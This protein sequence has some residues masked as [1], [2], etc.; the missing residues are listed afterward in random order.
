M[1]SQ[2]NTLPGQICQHTQKRRVRLWAGGEHVEPAMGRQIGGILLPR[3]DGKGP[4]PGSWDK[5][6]R[7]RQRRTVRLEG[8]QSH[9]H[10]R[11]GRQCL[12]GGWAVC[13]VLCGL[14]S[15]VSTC[16]QRSAG[17]AADGWP[18]FWLPS[19]PV[20]DSFITVSS[21]WSLHIYSSMNWQSLSLDAY[22]LIFY[23]WKRI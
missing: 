2:E 7:G 22:H 23:I 10:R 18:Q 15:C 9:T 1:V 6:S 20:I 13:R 5:Q 16:M 17:G 14:Y 19:S 21:R 11:S 8:E 12:L 4:A 3:G